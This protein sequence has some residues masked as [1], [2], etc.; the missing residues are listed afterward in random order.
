[1]TKFV[2]GCLTGLLAGS[3][4]TYWLIKPTSTDQAASLAA[5]NNPPKPADSSSV[6]AAPL[7]S[8]GAA[9]QGPDPNTAQPVPA[10]NPA[11]QAMATP[12][13]SVP[14]SPPSAGTTGATASHMYKLPVSQGARKLLDADRAATRQYKTLS[15][16]HDQLE[17]EPQDTN[18]AYYQETQ[19]KNF[20]ASAAAGLTADAVV[21]KQTL[22]EIQ[23]SGPAGPETGNLWNQRVV[24]S[25]EQQPWWR[26][27][28]GTSGSSNGDH[29]GTAILMILHRRPSP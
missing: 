25:M 2:G 5:T 24:P 26:D 13:A 17:E 21:C 6:D 3:L 28:E 10:P 29:Q 23:V 18:W 15:Q 22:C 12:N 16:L 9:M 8:Q 11:V 27:F 20:L 19:I 1:M 14:A 7:K 4:F